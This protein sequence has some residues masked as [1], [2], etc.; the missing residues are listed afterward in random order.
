MPAGNALRR[1]HLRNGDHRKAAHQPKG[2]LVR[3]MSQTGGSRRGLF[4]RDSPKKR[5]GRPSVLQEICAFP[6]QKEQDAHWFCTSLPARR[7]RMSC[8][9]R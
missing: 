5:L 8:L 7:G 2:A 6:N 4:M 9:P 1:E 3:P